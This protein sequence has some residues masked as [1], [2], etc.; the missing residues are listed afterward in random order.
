MLNRLRYARRIKNEGI[1]NELSK[2]EKMLNRGFSAAGA[3]READGLQ[4]T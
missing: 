4:E 1:Q 3:S 2:P